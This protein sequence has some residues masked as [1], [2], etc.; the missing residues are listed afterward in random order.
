MSWGLKEA[1]NSRSRNFSYRAVGPPPDSNPIH[2]P[3]FAAA[4]LLSSLLFSLGKP[5]SPAP[6]DPDLDSLTGQGFIMDNH[7]Q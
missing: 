5:P 6:S 2:T 7:L 3:T 4:L 1:G